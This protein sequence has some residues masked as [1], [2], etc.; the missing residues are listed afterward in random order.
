MSETRPNIL[1]IT[2]DQQRFD[3]IAALGNQEIFTPHLDWLVDEG[4]AYTRAYSDCPICVPA[5]CTIMSGK[6]GF[7]LG[8]TGNSGMEKGMKDR[9]T[10]PG[11]LTAAGYQTRAQGKMHF[12]PMRCNYGFEHME[13][14]LE[15]YRFIQ[16][17]GGAQPKEHGVG[18]NEMTPVI[19]T[20]SE[21][22]SLTH[23]IVQRSIDFLE[24]RDDTRPF[25]MWTSFGKPHPPLDPC[26]N[27]WAL[28]A[29]REVSPPVVGDWSETVEG[30]PQGFMAAT[31]CLNNAW[32]MSES[33]L[34]D[35]KRAYYACITQVDYQLG[36]MFA[37]LRE[38]GLLENTWI[39]FTADH[40]EMLGDHHMGAKSVYLEPSTHVPLLIRPPSGSRDEKPEKGRR[41]ETLAQLADVMPTILGIAGVDGP[42]D[43]D[44]VDLRSLGGEDRLFVG[45]CSR[46]QHVAMRGRMKLCFAAR[47]GDELLFDLEKDPREQHNL[48]N[49]PACADT[50]EVLRKDLRQHLAAHAPALIKDGKISP[51]PP[52]A[53]PREVRKWPGFHS[54][55]VQSDV[56][57]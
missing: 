57:H 44:G 29:N 22:D 19:S 28:Y 1:L 35:V 39:I 12:T 13:L 33:Q 36:L 4:V 21:Q 40:G 27:Y 48:V 25:F 26:A 5:R 3:T 31:Y 9:P 53:G 34:M 17:R 24:T 38:M 15:Y 51:L 23:W 30:T 6:H 14:Q 11:L 46:D 49:D 37:R 54:T 42:A 18:E 32:R 43:M 45:T 41:V 8:I 10:L 56:L 52:I 16:R 2:T 20:V 55:V 7:N 47:G 50:L